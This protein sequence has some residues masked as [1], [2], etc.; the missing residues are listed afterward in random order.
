MNDKIITTPSACIE[1]T[2]GHI[3]KTVLMPG[4]P[5]RAKYVAE[6]YL[7]DPVLFNTVR[8]MLGY[9]GTYEGGRW[10]NE[11]AVT[12]SDHQISQID[13]VK[14]V[15]FE[16]PEATDALFSRVIQK[17]DTTVD[18]ISGATVTS[19]AYLKSIENALSH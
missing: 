7:K 14:T 10:S 5:L 3:A 15:K 11:V 19:K 9:T 2:Q 8:N 4:D 18:V 16:K 17:Q 6:H 1:V 12:I 13:V